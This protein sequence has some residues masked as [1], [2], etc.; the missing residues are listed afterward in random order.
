M[1]LIGNQRRIGMSKKPKMKVVETVE[2]PIS[3]T[4]SAESPPDTPPIEKPP[5][6]SVLERFKSKR[7]PLIAGVETLQTALPHFRISDANDWC[8][9]HSDRVNYWSCELCFVL[10][11]IKGAKDGHLHLIDETLAM[12][13]LPSKRIQRFGLALATKPHDNFFL[14]HIPTQNLDNAWN[15]TNQQACEEAT[16]HW[17]QATSQK[18]EGLERYKIDF[19]K[20]PKAFPNPKWPSASLDSLIQVTFANRMIFDEQHPGLK[21]L[22][23]D[24]II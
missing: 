3:V 24:E 4:A 18:A 16:R 6:T 10:V 2:E 22:L 5:E 15:E 13:H 17:T 8:R 9:L 19:S 12:L 1:I 7:S 11:P 23:G 14:C 20:S 21:R